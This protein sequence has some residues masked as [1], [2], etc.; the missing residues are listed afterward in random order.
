M[1]EGR[2]DPEGSDD[3]DEAQTD[4]R[5][6]SVHHLSRLETTSCW[7]GRLRSLGSLPFHSCVVV[8]GGNIDSLSDSSDEDVGRS[9]WILLL[10]S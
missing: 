7:R 6:D 1:V 10:S 9:E 3:H 4:W 5:G 2:P 8:C